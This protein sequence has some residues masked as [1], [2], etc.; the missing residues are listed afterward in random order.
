MLI[1][2]DMFSNVFKI[3]EL[4]QII[5]PVKVVIIIKDII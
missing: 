4:V 1:I 5:L 3:A 2:L